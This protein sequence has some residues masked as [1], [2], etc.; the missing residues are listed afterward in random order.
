MLPFLEALS[1][2][3]NYICLY[4][5]AQHHD[6]F[7]FCLPLYHEIASVYNQQMIKIWCSYLQIDVG[8]DGIIMA[9]SSSFKTSK[10]TDYQL[11]LSNFGRSSL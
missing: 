6:T 8:G 4:A 11:H 9:R 2:H 3:F 10:L 5:R 1:P 7:P